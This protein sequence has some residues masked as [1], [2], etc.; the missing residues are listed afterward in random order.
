AAVMRE[1]NRA[2]IFIGAAAVADY[3]PVA[4]APQKIKKTTTHLT[5]ELERTPDVLAEAA[6][7]DRGNNGLIVVGFAAE[8][9]DAIRHA[10]E[11]LE[12]KKLDL[13]VANDVTLPGAGFGTETNVVSLITADRPAPLTLPL[14][15][16]LD[17]AHR[18]LDEIAA[19]RAAKN[20]SAALAV[21]EG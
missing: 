6:L 1:I 3:R 21:Q 4:V 19:L 11:K 5:L 15:T 8:T 7:A 14:L 12:R 17:V 20:E 10:R 2:T 18:I 16:K 13:I 9:I